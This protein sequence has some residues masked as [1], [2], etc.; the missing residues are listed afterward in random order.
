LNPASAP[1]TSQTTRRWLSVEQLTLEFPAFTRPAIRALIQRSRPHYNHRGEWTAG[2]GLAGVIC[3]PGG[4]NGKV[5]IDADG[6]ARW[7]ESWVS[8][9]VDSSTPVQVTVNASVDGGPHAAPAT[10]LMGAIR[11]AAH[12]RSTS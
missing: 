7:L 4:K 3:Q 10:Q 6:F 2:N 5:M 9:T 11:G 1:R 8:N 12:Y